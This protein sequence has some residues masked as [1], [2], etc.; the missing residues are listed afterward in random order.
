MD[1]ASIKKRKMPCMAPAVQIMAGLRASS[2]CAKT[3]YTSQYSKM[4]LK[5]C[6]RCRRRRTHKMR[7]A[8]IKSTPLGL[9][10][11]WC[12]SAPAHHRISFIDFTSPQQKPF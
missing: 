4:G 12:R 8:N 9:G 6:A 2:V 11:R 10:W 5:S 3:C 7:E 1:E